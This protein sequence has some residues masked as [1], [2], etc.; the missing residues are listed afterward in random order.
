MKKEDF[1]TGQKFIYN[2]KTYIVRKKYLPLSSDGDERLAVNNAIHE[3]TETVSILNKF[4]ENGMTDKRVLEMADTYCK[5]GY[6][7]IANLINL[8]N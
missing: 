8:A 6:S 7:H 4:L 5:R 3:L 2:G 1:N